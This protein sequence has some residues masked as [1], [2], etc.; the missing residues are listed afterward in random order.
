MIRLTLQQAQNLAGIYDDDNDFIR[1]SKLFSWLGRRNHRCISAD[2]RTFIQ[3][4]ESAEHDGIE[5]LIIKETTNVN[6]S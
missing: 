3:E 6:K 5:V 4:I 1:D 2:S